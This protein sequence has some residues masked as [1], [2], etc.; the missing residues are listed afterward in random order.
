[1]PAGSAAVGAVSLLS[2]DADAANESKAICPFSKVSEDQLMDLHRC[3]GV[4]A[5]QMGEGPGY[6]PRPTAGEYPGA[7]VLLAGKGY[8]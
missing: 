3:V 2:S 1:M 6:I 8:H 4:T 5:G 7:R